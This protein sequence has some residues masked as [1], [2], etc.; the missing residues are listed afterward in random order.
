MSQDF[1]TVD[2]ADLLPV[3]ERHTLFLAFAQDLPERR[4]SMR[5][6]AHERDWSG[7]RRLA[8]RLKGAALLYGFSNLGSQAAELESFAGNADQS[9]SVLL[10]LELVLAGCRDVERQILD[11]SNGEQP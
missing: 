1:T 10:L 8:H 6:A 4:E 2:A 11:D 9:D 3:S 7:L 5:R